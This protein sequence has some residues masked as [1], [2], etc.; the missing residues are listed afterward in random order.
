[1]SVSGWQRRMEIC[2]SN[3]MSRASKLAVWI[4][5]VAV[6]GLSWVALSVLIYG[7]WK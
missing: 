3:E 6:G 4:I 2:G 7:V 5:V 1:M